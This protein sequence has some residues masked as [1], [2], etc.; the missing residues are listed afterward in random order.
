MAR[1]NT[2]PSLSPLRRPPWA[3]AVAGALLGL[4]LTLVLQAPA[5]WLGSLLA[6]LSHDQVMLA[7]ARGSVWT[8]SARLQLTGGAGSRDQSALPGRIQWQLRPRWTSL[9]LQLGADCCTTAPFDIA[10]TPHWGGGLITVNDPPNP[11]PSHWP[12]AL[13]IGLGAPWNTVQV[14]GQLLL[15]THQLSLSWAEGRPTLGGSAELQALA[16][17]SRLSTLKPM[18]SYRIQLHGGASPTLEVSTIEGS[19]QLSGSGRWV[20]PR[21]HF[22]GEASA[23]PDR[24]AA[25]SNLLNILGRRKGGRTV[26]TVG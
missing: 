17:S 2:A 18:G 3:W 26:I 16:V 10:L 5:R 24:E 9:S 21:L 14:E 13:L 12:A 22:T 7:E 19:L 4:M 20:G 6:L 11:T 1:R 25:L 8:G 23:T 15:N